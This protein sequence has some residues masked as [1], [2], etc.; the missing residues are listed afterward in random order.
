MGTGCKTIRP[1][2]T[3]AERTFY[4]Q[5]TIDTFKRWMSLQGNYINKQ[6]VLQ[7]LGIEETAKNEDE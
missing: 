7:I 5:G 1:P 3:A 6:E 4:L 2:I